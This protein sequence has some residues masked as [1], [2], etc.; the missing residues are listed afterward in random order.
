MKIN[1]IIVLLWIVFGV[2]AEGMIINYFYRLGQKSNYHKY[3][4]Y[5]ELVE[6][7]KNRLTK[8]MDYMTAISQRANIYETEL[9]KLFT[10]VEEI[11]DEIANLDVSKLT[12]GE[13]K[14][15]AI[16]IANAKVI[17]RA[18]GMEKMHNEMESMSNKIDKIREAA[19]Q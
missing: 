11:T 13:V 17:E 4:K 1:D 5:F 14:F 18:E 7:Y 8:T 10:A 19:E 6:K 15:R 3:S 12:A 16:M 2:I 9:N